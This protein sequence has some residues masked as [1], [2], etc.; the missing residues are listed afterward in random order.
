MMFDHDPAPLGLTVSQAARFLGVSPGTVR[1]WADTGYLTGYR[2]P[3]GQRRFNH[4]DLIAF[5]RRIQMRNV[6]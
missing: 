5:A 1:R 3:G 6:A 2:T 4:T